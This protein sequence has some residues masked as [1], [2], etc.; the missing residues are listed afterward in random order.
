MFLGAKLL[1]INIRET[2]PEQKNE[3]EQMKRRW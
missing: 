2:P 1:G 3:I